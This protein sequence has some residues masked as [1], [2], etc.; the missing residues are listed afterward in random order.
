M[1]I[2]EVIKLRTSQRGFLERAGAMLDKADADGKRCLRGAEVDE[3]QEQLS[4]I[5]KIREQLQD[6]DDDRDL[7]DL[8]AALEK[9]ARTPQP[10]IAA[11]HDQPG[12]HFVTGGGSIEHNDNPRFLT[13]SQ[14]LSELPG[15]NREDRDQLDWAKAIRGYAT[16]RLDDFS[17]EEKRILQEGIGGSGGFTIS[18]TQSSLLIDL[19]RDAAVCIQAGTQTVL[20]DQ[21]EAQIAVIL[22][23]PVSQFVPEGGTISPSDI[24]FGAIH[25]K[26]GILACMARCSIQLLQDSQGIDAIIRRGLTS[27]IGLALD[28]AIL[29][30]SGVGG[31]RGIFYTPGIGTVSCGVNG[32]VPTNYD[33]FLDAIA[34]V[35]AAN[36]VAGQVV[37]NSRTKATLAKLKTAVELDTLRPPDDYAKLG[38]FITNAIPSDLVWGSATAC[39]MAIVGDFRQS[40]IALAPTGAGGSRAIRID[41]STT[42]SGFDTLNVDIRAFLRID[43]AVAK[44]NHFARI[45]GILAA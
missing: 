24:N 42:G 41:I 34:A 12:G 1:T 19:S 5:H 11:G 3:F 30:G 43:A 18:E 20:L 23:D 22:S 9:R 38:Q 27:S 31:P 4:E 44:A 10:T 17:P 7:V 32:S 14:K 21:A 40:L 35:E 8:E 36:G 2:Q 26:A 13:R 25:V 37:M 39:S 16:G 45:C 15:L 29:Q 6:H 33:Y 28:S